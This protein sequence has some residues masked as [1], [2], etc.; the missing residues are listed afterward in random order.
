MAGLTLVVPATEGGI[1]MI[2]QVAV[3]P[4]PAARRVLV[5]GWSQFV[6][7]CPA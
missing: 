2:S 7:N 3:I 1:L 6:A 4:Q 5:R